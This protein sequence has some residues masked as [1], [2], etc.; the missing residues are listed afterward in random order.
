[1]SDSSLCF[2]ASTN[3]SQIIQERAR[4]VAPWI[5]AEARL[6]KDGKA[7]RRGTEKVVQIKV[8]PETTV[9]PTVLPPFS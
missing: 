4:E 5:E 3:L 6:T 1:M 2:Y 8:K 9:C 7:L